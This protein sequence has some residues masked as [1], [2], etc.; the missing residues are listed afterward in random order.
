MFPG[1]AIALL[2]ITMVEEGP[3]DVEQFVRLIAGLQADIHDAA[4]AFEGKEMPIP[5]GATAEQVARGEVVTLGA[6]YQ[7]AFAFREDGAC[8]LDFFEDY[9]FEGEKPTHVY[10][11]AA[12]LGGDLHEVSRQPQLRGERPGKRPGHPLS[13]NMPH[14]PHRIC[15]VPY[16]KSLKDPSVIGYDYLG[17]EVVDGHRCLN[18]SIDVSQGVSERPPGR[19]V[20]LFWIDLARGGHP[21]KIVF[22]DGLGVS[23]RTVGIE[24]S[25][26]PI[27]GGREVWFPVRGYT[28]IYP[29]ARG[30]FG[31]EPA[32]VET[33]S[34][35]SG[36]LRFNR[37]L[38]DDLF[39]PDRRT[40]LDGK[41]PI[42]DANLKRRRASFREPL[43]RRD[44]ASVKE[45]LDQRLAE[46]DA[47]SKQ[48]EAS[49][50]AR[51]GVGWTLWI[52]GSLIGGG[53]VLLIVAV[54]YRLRT[55]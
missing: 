30:S 43:P 46:A 41:N 18:V 38:P 47:Q 12:L 17:W 44:P 26:F 7:G 53:V 1:L 4:F 40:G 16:F 29:I 55:H 34:I 32:A 33:Y 45:Q 8:L 6:S 51:G 25:K 28:E 50:P 37:G 21:L 19:A 2:S 54:A 52:Q 20:M 14:S 24:L 39:K 27:P 10:R 15:F 42:D 35:L 5:S 48:L 23:M 22:R 3:V 49:S 11:T 31:K 36:M 13:F 9:A